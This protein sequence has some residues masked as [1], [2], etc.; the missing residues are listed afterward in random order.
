VPLRT[1]AVRGVAKPCNRFGDCRGLRRGNP[2]SIRGTRLL[3]RRAENR[4]V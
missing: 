3:L 1:W 4:L 2:L